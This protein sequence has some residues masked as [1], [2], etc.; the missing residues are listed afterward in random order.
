[1]HEYSIARA[2]IERI[3]AEAASRRASAVTFVLVRIGELSGVDPELLATA[4]R[5]VAAPT[6]CSEA[7]L[8]IVPVPARWACRACGAAVPADGPRRCGVCGAAAALQHGDEIMLERIEMDIDSDREEPRD[9]RHG[10][11]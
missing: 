3:D 9:V 4:Y 5:I 6:I 11:P 8:E 2:L 10:R 7:R 1:M